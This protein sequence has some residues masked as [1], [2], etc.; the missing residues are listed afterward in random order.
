VGRGKLSAY[1]YDI[2]NQ[3]V[4]VASNRSAGLRWTGTSKVSGKALTYTLEYA[5]QVDA[6]DQP[7]NYSANYYH[8]DLALELRK[9]TPSIGYESLGG[10]RNRFGAAFQTPLATLHGFNGWADKFTITPAAGVN[11]LFLGLKGGFGA[12]SW[13]LVFHDFDAESGSE[14]YGKELD[15]SLSRKFGE[16]YGLLL[17]AARFDGESTPLYDDVIKFWV[18]FTADF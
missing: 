7:V 18:Q 9:V 4:A 12:W 8:V 5:H 17:K 2:D 10:D 11:D 1:V 6:H 3:D 15:G 16:H 13:N 14:S